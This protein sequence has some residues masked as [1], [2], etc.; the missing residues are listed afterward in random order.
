MLF[1]T[2]NFS[3]CVQ[4]KRIYFSLG[5]SLKVVWPFTTSFHVLTHAVL[6]KMDCGLRTD[7][8][9]MPTE[10]CMSVT[11]YN[12]WVT[13]HQ[14]SKSNTSNGN[15]AIHH[16]IISKMLLLLTLVLVVLIWQLSS[17]APPTLLSIFIVIKSLSSRWFGETYEVW[18]THI[19]RPETS[20]LCMIIK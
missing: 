19:F 16:T 17:K 4:T 15:F 9:H 11:D 2:R 12:N 7:A 20:K 3:L 1:L 8:Q 5:L 13:T 18:W 6:Q 14:S 10:Q